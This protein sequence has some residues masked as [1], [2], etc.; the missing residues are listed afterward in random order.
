MVGACDVVL[1][2]LVFFG[3]VASQ[4]ANERQ[5][6]RIDICTFSRLEQKSRTSA[7]QWRTN[8]KNVLCTSEATAFHR[9]TQ[10][11]TEATGHHPNLQLDGS[12]H[13]D[14][15]H[16]WSHQQRAEASLGQRSNLSEVTAIPMTWA[17]KQPLLMVCREIGYQ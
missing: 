5:R 3:I 11:L 4:L 9:L 7:I 10:F 2:Q 16:R 13:S 1:A 6:V 14:H 15:Q 17:K 8:S 12:C